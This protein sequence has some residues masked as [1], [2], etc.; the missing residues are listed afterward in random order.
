VVNPLFA[1]QGRVPGLVITQ[2]S[3]NPGSGYTARIRGQSSIGAGS[4]P[5]YVI[6][7]IPYS[8]SLNG[9]ASLGISITAN[10]FDL[11]NPLNFLNPLD[12]ESISVLKDADATAIYG[13]RGANGV[14]L[15]VTKKGNVGA[16]ATANISYGAGSVAHYMKLL[17][18]QQYVTMRKE[19]F[20]N[21]SVVYDVNSAPD[22]VAWDTT[23][24]TD[25]QKQL[26]GG[27]APVTNAQLSLSGGNKNTQ[28]LISG[29]FIKTGS[30]YIGD[31]ADT[32]GSVNLSINNISENQKFKLSMN[33]LYLNDNNTLPQFDPTSV[34]QQ[35]P[36]N[37]PDFL[38]SKGNLLWPPFYDFNPYAYSKYEYLSQSNN[39]IGN[40]KLGYQIAQDLDLSCDFGF[41]KVTVNELQTYPI[42][43]NNPA[44]GVT[45]GRSVFGNNANQVWNIEPQL[46]WK[47]HFGG[48]KLSF[49][50]GAT[51]QGSLLQ[52]N[53]INANGYTTDAL[54]K[55]INSAGSLQS[56][57]SYYFQYRYNAFFG[58]INYN[59][60]D[61]Y[62]VSLNGRR[63]GSSRFGPGNQ[64]ANFG[65]VG[66]AWIFS[67]EPF[68]KQ[69]ISFLS[70]G[71]LRGSYGVAGNDQIPD[72]RYQ[73]LWRS[74]GHPFQNAPTL[75]VSN[76]SN[77]DY[78]WE[79]D[80]KTEV[81]INLGFLKDYI[82]FEMDYYLNK[83]DNMLLQLP[84]PASTGWQG[85]L[86]NLPAKVQNT[87]LEFSLNTTNIRTHSFNWTTSLN[88]TIPRNK[89]VAYP[90][91]ENSPYATTYV[92]GKSLYTQFSYP[93]LG[94]DPSTGVFSF[95]SVQ[96]VATSAPSYPKDLKPTKQVAQ[97]FYGGLQNSLTYMGFQ[98][99][100]L[101]QFVQQ[102]GYSNLINN[103]F[104][105]PGE[106]NNQ[107]LA[108]LNR[109]QKPGDNTE[110]QKFTT[111]NGANG[112]AYNA[113]NAAAFRGDNRITDA[114]FIRL[115]NVAISYT[116]PKILSQRIK[117]SQFRIYVQAQNLL[118][119]T[120]FQ[121][122]DP[123]TLGVGL[124][125]P[126]RVIV[127]GIQITF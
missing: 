90:N 24:Y 51:F 59:Y 52:G 124:L 35:L 10:N 54:L 12:I 71:K 1:L 107:P 113:Y 55:D 75:S 49:L 79:R 98:L 30:V 37:T 109:W 66:A 92:V 33:V 95:Q 70:F 115:K 62:I 125:P 15:I 99:D 85:V 89:L 68:F 65:S 50:L 18:T 119:I 57:G 122:M 104:G 76:L 97:D 74:T 22:L 82:L 88:I 7:G 28:Y 114:S 64:F 31:F 53:T 26:L 32:R 93:Y 34:A 110:F 56:Q 14:I 87:G 21:D 123:E 8:Q 80:R 43:A 116:L 91:I 38:D 4:N 42:S 36:P 101:F 2:N 112:T 100:F 45:T 27:T 77:S 11:L 108:V 41:N 60:K 61:K 126:L 46:N 29:N 121:G 39:L 47:K 17:N 20:A 106:F 13:S 96:G 19:A 6:D 105:P 5:L 86:A 58:R 16:K 23:K 44:D 111:G 67:E 118:T 3:G 48:S 69:N 83:S 40:L 81:G 117:S 9:G 127:G 84:L 78:G 73:Q 120:S 63:D 103:S 25:W 94:V 102:T 72:Y